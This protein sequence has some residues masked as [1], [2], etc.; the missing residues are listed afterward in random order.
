MEYITGTS[1]AEVLQGQS[2]VCEDPSWK[3]PV[4]K[5]A[6]GDKIRE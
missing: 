4:V 2:K 6:L 1:M 3:R 5:K